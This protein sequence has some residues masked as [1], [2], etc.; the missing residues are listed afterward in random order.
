MTTFA[1]MII[2]PQILCN[3]GLFVGKPAENENQKDHNG[4]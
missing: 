1:F 4:Q 3:F 2:Y